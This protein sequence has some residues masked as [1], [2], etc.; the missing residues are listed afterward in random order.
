MFTDQISSFLQTVNT[1]VTRQ[2]YQRGLAQF[3]NWYLSSYDEEPDATL[4][5]EEEGRSGALI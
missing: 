5:T 3:H 1:A 2:A 4:L